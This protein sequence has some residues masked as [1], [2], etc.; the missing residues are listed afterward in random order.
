MSSKKSAVLYHYTRRIQD[1][2]NCIARI[3]VVCA[4]ASLKRAKDLRARVHSEV[5]YA[6]AFTLPEG[7]S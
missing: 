1:L 7:L 4:D 2:E 5:A 6:Q 3:S